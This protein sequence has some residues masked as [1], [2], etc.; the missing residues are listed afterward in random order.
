MTGKSESLLPNDLPVT[1]GPWTVSHESTRGDFAWINAPEN[2]GAYVVAECQSHAMN[3]GR[4]LGDARLLAAAPLLAEALATIMDNAA[5]DISVE[6]WKEG[7]EALVAALGKRHAF[8]AVIR[9]WHDD[10]IDGV[11]E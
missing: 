2:E 6:A 4:F 7:R 8:E 1:P 9:W 10:H 11:L 3:R 5:D